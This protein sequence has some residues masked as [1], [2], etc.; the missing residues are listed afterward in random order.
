MGELVFV[1]ALWTFPG[2]SSR[3]CAGFVEHLHHQMTM[4]AARRTAENKPFMNDSLRSRHKKSPRWFLL[5][6]DGWIRSAAARE[7]RVRWL[8]A[9]E[10][11]AV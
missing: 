8:K 4:E 10:A 5:L 1:P 9:N 2:P 3:I 11:R 6:F 7:R